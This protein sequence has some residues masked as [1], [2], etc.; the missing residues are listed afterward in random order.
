MLQLT[1]V[2]YKEINMATANTT[3]L[4]LLGK[5]ISFRVQYKVP[6]QF[7]DVFST[8]QILSGLVQSVIVDL[9]GV[10]EILVDGEFHVLSEIE[11]L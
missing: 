7:K 9:H 4:E 11:I 5:E 8:S 6:E 10:H 3:V 1:N 2:I